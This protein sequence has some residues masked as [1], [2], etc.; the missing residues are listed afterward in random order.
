MT[1][2]SKVVIFIEKIVS[3]R[4]IPRYLNDTKIGRMC[5]LLVP[6]VGCN[7]VCMQMST[8]LFLYMHVDK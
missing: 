2:L 3:C 6:W 1:S 7:A 8:S 5:I 4:G